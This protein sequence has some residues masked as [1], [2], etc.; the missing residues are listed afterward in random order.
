MQVP[1]ASLT[2][3]VLH[4]YQANQGP[5]TWSKKAKTKAKHLQIMSNFI[6]PIKMPTRIHPPK[7][8][9]IRVHLG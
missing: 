4:T 5:V 3:G 6:G 9:S 8:G 7:L 1:N 2:P